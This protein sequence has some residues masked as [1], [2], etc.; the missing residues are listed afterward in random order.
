MPIHDSQS[1][2]FFALIA[3]AADNCFSPFIHAVID[4]TNDLNYTDDD[5]ILVVE[6]RDNYGNRIIKN[7][8]EVEIFKSGEDISLTLLWHNVDHMPILWQG[9]HSFWMNSD[10]GKRCSSPNDAH[11]FESFSRKVRSLFIENI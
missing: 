7:D 5:Y 9:K 4:K 1:I 6:C 2:D 8:I 11:L 10:D 3:K